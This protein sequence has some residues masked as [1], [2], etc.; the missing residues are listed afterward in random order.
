MQNPQKLK[1][2]VY[3]YFNA[4][5]LSDAKAVAKFFSGDAVYIDTALNKEYRG[6]EIEQY[7]SNIFS[8]SIGKV[9]FSIVQP[10]VI[11]DDVV[12]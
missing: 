12:L 3:D 9:Q 5:N 10:P 6:I 7:V 4:W 1:Q 11:N 2:L 8:G